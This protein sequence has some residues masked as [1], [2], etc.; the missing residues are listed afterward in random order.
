[1]AKEITIIMPN[2]TTT[3]SNQEG[4]IPINPPPAATKASI[5]PNFT[6]NLVSIAQVADAGYNTFFEPTTVKIINNNTKKVEWKGTRNGATGLWK[7]PLG[8][9]IQTVNHQTIKNKEMV[10]NATTIGK[11]IEEYITFLH[12]AYVSPVKST[13]LKAI[14]NNHFKSWP[15]LTAQN[16]NKYLGKTI[17]TMKDHMPQT[18]KNKGKYRKKE[19]APTPKE[20]EI[21]NDHFP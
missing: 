13:W 17:H 18:K 11:S 10:Y 2:N 20:K 21:D 9:T 8:K 3:T 12:Q 15:K 7:L 14:N 5:V 1:M 19:A 6:K 4:N 16:V